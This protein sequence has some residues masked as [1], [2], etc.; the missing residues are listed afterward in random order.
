MNKFV[1]KL[2]IVL[3]PFYPLWGWLSYT[4]VHRNVGMFVTLLCAPFAIV[5]LIKSEKKIPKYLIFFICFT[6]Y[7]LI[8]VYYHDL[9]LIHSTNWF[10]FILSD[11]NVSACL[12]FIIVENLAFEKKYFDILSQCIFL[13]IIVTLA[14]SLIQIKY[15]DFFISP[16]I[17]GEDG[18]DLIYLREQRS[19]SFYSWANLNSLGI[20]F[21]IFI[22]LLLGIKNSKKGRHLIVTL[23][24]ILVALLGRARYIMISVV[25]VIS[26]LFFSK[27]VTLRKKLLLFAGIAIGA[28][29]LI[30]IMSSIGFNIDQVISDR[31]LEKD[32]DMSSAMARVTSY[33]VFVLKFPEHPWWGVG[34]ETRDDVKDL[35]GDSIPLIHIGYL[36]YL[37]YYGVIGSFIFLLS[38]YYLSREAWKVGR[39]T[40]FW[41]SFY[42]LLT[43]C[44]ANLTFVYF[45]LSEAG[46]IMAVVFLRYYANIM[47]DNTQ[48]NTF[49]FR[50]KREN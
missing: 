32:T 2:F 35:L 45:N 19:F 46:I 39:K 23:C 44:I 38:L 9:A 5:Y 26:Q 13:S 47:V 6:I 48:I 1:Q 42:G 49:N 36:S 50:N 30:N 7:H 34:P 25:V 3:F 28:I 43:F 33:E 22:S 10:A 29:F 20:T 31:I 27:K 14:V 17:M 4:L 15:I 11:I 12:I 24:G 40:K 16:E 18:G 41:G 37:Y 21:P 8:S